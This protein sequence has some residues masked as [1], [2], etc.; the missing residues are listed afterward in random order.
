MENSNIIIVH[1]FIY[2]VWSYFVYSSQGFEDDLV[3]TGQQKKLVASLKK[4]EHFTSYPLHC[5]DNYLI[6][7][8]IRKRIYV[9]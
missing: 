5:I 4:M 8:I 2:P 3:M 6:K 1:S 7:S 9:W